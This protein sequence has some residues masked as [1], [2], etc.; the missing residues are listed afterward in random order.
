MIVL[1]RRAV[2]VRAMAKTTGLSLQY[3]SLSSK[4]HGAASPTLAKSGAGGTETVRTRRL[5]RALLIVV[6]TL[7][8]LIGFLGVGAVTMGNDLI[9]SKTE[10]RPMS[11]FPHYDGAEPKWESNLKI[12]G[13]C[14]TS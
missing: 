8:V 13:G 14:T 4:W 7:I 5:P 3:C 11:E 10:R 6:G 9:C 1:H 2:T 12:T